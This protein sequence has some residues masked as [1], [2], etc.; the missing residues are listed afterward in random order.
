MSTKPEWVKNVISKGKAY[1]LGGKKHWTYEKIDKS[2][3]ET[4]QAA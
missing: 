2:R 1:L 4:I 3:D